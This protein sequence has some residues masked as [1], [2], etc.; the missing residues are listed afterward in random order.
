MLA[1]WDLA[2]D[3]EKVQLAETLAKKA[4][5]MSPLMTDIQFKCLQVT[6]I[7]TE[8]GIHGVAKFAQA[9]TANEFKVYLDNEQ[10]GLFKPGQ[11]YALGLAPAVVI[12]T[13]DEFPTNQS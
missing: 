11:Y 9:S 5:P 1:K 7:A 12:E 2:K 10:I 4:G 8:A 13:A 6:V 3:Y